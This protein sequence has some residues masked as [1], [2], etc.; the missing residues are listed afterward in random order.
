MLAN[1]IDLQQQSMMSSLLYKRPAI[2]LFD[3]AAA[4]QSLLQEFLL[5]MLELLP[6]RRH[7]ARLARS[8]YF[9]HRGCPT[10]EGHRWDALELAAGIRQGYPLSPLLLVVIVDGLLPCI[11]REAPNT[12]VRMYADDTAIVVQDVWKWRCPR[13]RGSH[14]HLAKRHSYG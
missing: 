11:L 10:L 2:V 5:E 3:F 1:D 4:F 13:Y 12:F 14:R 6:I 8:L 7:V 9:E